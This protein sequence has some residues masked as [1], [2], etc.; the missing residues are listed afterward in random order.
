VLELLTGAGLAASAGLNAYI[1]LLA[2]GLL[3]RYTSLIHPSSSWHWLANGWVLLILAL[4]LAIEVVAD[5]IPAIDSLNDVL[6]TVIRPTSGGLAFGAASQSQTVT[7][8]DPGR[9][10]TGHQWIPI[11]AGVVIALCVHGTKATARPV[12][13]VSTLG[14]G[15]PVV[16]TIEDIFSVVMS[17]V[18]I[19]MPF[20]IVLFLAGFVWFFV[21]A[22]RRWR[23]RKAG[24]AAARAASLPGGAPPGP[25]IQA[26]PRSR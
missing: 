22:L 24:K 16:S 23:R 21:W 15:A 5:K 6:H 12:I 19:V 14:V 1:P 20:L 10:F 13:N 3:A 26:R 2:I 4:L 9:F 8:S 11:V 17:V 7:V 25:P 18:A